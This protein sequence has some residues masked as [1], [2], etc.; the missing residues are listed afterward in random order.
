MPDVPSTEPSVRRGLFISWAPFSRRTE[1]LARRLDLD[2]VQV[3]A[4]WFKRPLFAPLKYPAQIV[5]TWR[6]L[7][8]TRPAE[9]W[10]MDPPAPA[11]LTA[12]L[13]CY[14]RRLPLV[15]DMHT[16]GFYDPKW[17][18][19]RRLELPALRYAACN[20]VTNED[21]AAR[22]RAWG[23]RTAILTD[24][25]PD[26]P[27]AGD[28]RPEAGS[29]TI[30]ATFSEDEPIDRLPAVARALPDVKLYVTGR[31]RTDVHAWP[32]NLVA[33]GFVSDAEF[34]RRLRASDAVVVLTARPN[35]LL[36]GGYEAL[37]LG[38]P[39]VVSDQVVLRDYFGDAAVYVDDDAESIAAG[40]REALDHG[41]E[42]AAT[43][44]ALAEL[45]EAEW[46]SAARRL[47]AAVG[48]PA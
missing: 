8:A 7:A 40:I 31:P 16:V 14:R 20:V 47:C 32:S 48:R 19:L 24:P 25:L 34:W 11:V 2:C 26:P 29:A 41:D 23:C 13:Y 21:L 33:T 37:S 45:R 3:K 18:L 4:P 9:V 39:L 38:K 17:R 44:A 1:T 42:L 30:I 15:V 10:V 6:T 35:T 12:W 22:V 5:R 46:A 43:S 28:V 27:D 36:S